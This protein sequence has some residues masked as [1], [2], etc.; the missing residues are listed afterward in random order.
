M[1][2]PDRAVR[3]SKRYGNFLYTPVAKG[4]RPFHRVSYEKVNI[5]V[6]CYGT[7]DKHRTE[8]LEDL[9][10]GVSMYDSISENYLIENSLESSIEGHDVYHDLEKVRE[11]G[12]L[13]EED[14]GNL[15]EVIDE[16]FN[17]FH[18]ASS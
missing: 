16:E 17:Y 6:P 9:A 2:S 4:T 5:D 7:G 10:D 1:S 14:R 11:E 18:T 13:P 12:Y 15:E 8:L 3:R